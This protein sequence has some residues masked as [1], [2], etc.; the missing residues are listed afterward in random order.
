MWIDRSPLTRFTYEGTPLIPYA[1]LNSP[2]A[3]PTRLKVRVLI[4]SPDAPPGMK[5]AFG[6]KLSP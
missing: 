4:A 1:E 2:A 5:T 6:P 3:A